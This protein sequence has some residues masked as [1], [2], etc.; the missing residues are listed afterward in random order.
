LLTAEVTADGTNETATTGTGTTGSIAAEPAWTTAASPSGSGCLAVTSAAFAA[1]VFFFS[2]VAV[3]L[4][5]GTFS[6]FGVTGVAA[7]K[8]TGAFRGTGAATGCTTGFCVAGADEVAGVLNGTGAA[9]GC[10]VDFGAVDAGAL[11]LDA[12]LGVGFGDASAAGC[13]CKLCSKVERK[14]SA[15]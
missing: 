10:T 7:A 2:A 14:S 15:P 13:V 3:A 4:E 1:T 12:G 9:D 11:G 5:A 6:S 8:I